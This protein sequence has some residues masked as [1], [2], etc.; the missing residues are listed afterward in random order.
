MTTTDLSP[1][2][3]RRNWASGDVCAAAPRFEELGRYACPNNFH[4]VFVN[5]ITEKSGIP[6]AKTIKN[7]EVTSGRGRDC[8]QSDSERIY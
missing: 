4:M 7:E 1:T 5:H 6:D 3:V 2:D 8:G